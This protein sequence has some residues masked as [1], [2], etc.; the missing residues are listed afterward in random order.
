MDNI[1]FE[2]LINQRIDRELEIANEEK[3]S[4]RLTLR[5]LYKTIISE[6]KIELQNRVETYNKILEKY[7]DKYHFWLYFGNKFEQLDN[8]SNNLM[9]VLIDKNKNHPN[10]QTLVTNYNHCIIGFDRIPGID[11]NFEFLLNYSV[12]VSHGNNEIKDL[13]FPVNENDSEL[14]KSKIL[15]FF[16]LFIEACIKR[17]SELKLVRI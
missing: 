11:D 9:I 5:Y 17:S 8:K 7:N 15:N 3:L 13:K 6:I 16:I 1:Q 4:E 14:I 2:N 10:S 12:F